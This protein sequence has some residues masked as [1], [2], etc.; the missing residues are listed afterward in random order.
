[1]LQDASFMNRLIK[2]LNAPLVAAICPTERCN[3]ACTH[4][5]G[6]YGPRSSKN[7]LG[8]GTWLNIIDDLKEYIIKFDVT[9]GEPFFSQKTIKIL[10]H[11]KD[12]KAGVISINTNGTLVTQSTAS[13]LSK[14]APV[15]QFV[16]VSLDGASPAVH[17][18]IRGKGTYS[19]TIKGIKHLRARNIIV[20]VAAMVHKRTT[21]E[22]IEKMY[23]LAEELD[24]HVQYGTIFPVGQALKTWKSTLLAPRKLDEVSELIFRKEKNMVDKNEEI[25]TQMQMEQ[26][27]YSVERTLG[28]CSAGYMG[29]SL[30]SDGIVAAC[31]QLPL[32]H[33]FG[34]MREI[35][36]NNAFLKKIRDYGREHDVEVCMKCGKRLSCYKRCIGASYNAFG[37]FGAP[38][39]YCVLF[40]TQ[41]DLDEDLTRSYSNMLKRA[42]VDIA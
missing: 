34:N 13:M 32:N 24:F 42:G 20:T 26:E 39:P 36:K 14:L 8:L 17:E 3:L 19:L 37:D 11:I 22:D 9:G 15:L 5:V 7:E 4:C 12:E 30:M 41:L 27:Q 6:S 16:R 35:W 33:H 21:L 25:K 38:S 2:G 40:K 1:M 23:R 18:Y 28:R 31:P 10:Q 29:I